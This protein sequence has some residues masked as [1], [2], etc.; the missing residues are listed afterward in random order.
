MRRCEKVWSSSAA[1]RLLGVETR[2]VRCSGRQ[3]RVVLRRACRRGSRR[4]GG[5]ANGLLVPLLDILPHDEIPL[6]LERVRKMSLTVAG[7]F[8]RASVEGPA[9]A[10]GCISPQ[11]RRPCRVIRLS[12]MA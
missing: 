8:A 1:H 10:I 12:D 2:R 5:F 6:F 4:C 7:G 11:R 3:K 9:T